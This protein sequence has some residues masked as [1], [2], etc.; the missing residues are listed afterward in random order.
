LKFSLQQEFPAGVSGLWTAI[1]R[2]DYPQSKY[3][4]LGST[5]VAINRFTVTRD[6]IEVD[7]ERKVPVVRAGL[8]PGRAR[9][10]RRSSSCTT[11]R[12]GSA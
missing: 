8:R 7:L 2:P 12:A 4:A 5:D 10:P 11:T 3:L 1:G 6:L 9:S